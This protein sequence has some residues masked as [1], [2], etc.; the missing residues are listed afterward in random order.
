MLGLRGDALAQIARHAGF[1]LTPR[2]IIQT[3]A[4]CADKIDR[5]LPR[6]I[7]GTHQDHLLRRAQPRFERRGPVVH[8]GAL[9][10]GQV[11]QLQAP[12]FARRL[13]SR[14]ARADDIAIPERER[15]RPFPASSLRSAEPASPPRGMAISAPNFCACLWARA[16]KRQTANP[17]RK[18][19]I[20]LDT[21]RGARLTA[22]GAA[23][24]A[25]RL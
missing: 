19:E 7:A 20:V 15:G 4:A 24:D 12:I 8:A 3:F 14:A 1:E 18:A 2:T 10:L 6:G 5:R 13:R 11:R 9:E 16:I 23:V 21:G 22:E 25:P 17:R